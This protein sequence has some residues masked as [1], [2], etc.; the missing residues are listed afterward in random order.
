MEKRLRWCA[1]KF[2]YARGSSRLLHFMELKD[3]AIDDALDYS[4]LFFLRALRTR[5]G[6]E[7][8]RDE[9]LARWMDDTA[10]KLVGD[11]A[12][13]LLQSL[14]LD[15]QTPTTVGE[16]YPGIGATFEY[17]KLLLEDRSGEAPPSF[18]YLAFGPEALRLK[19]EVL[20]ADELFAARYYSD[21]GP[22][23]ARLKA[24]ERRP[25]LTIFNHNQ[26][27]RHRAEPGVSLDEFIPRAAG[28]TLLAA[29]ATNADVDELQTTVK[30]RAVTVPSL[31]QLGKLC[32]QTGMSWAF[33]FIPGFDKDFFLPNGDSRLGLLLAYGAGRPFL[34]PGFAPLPRS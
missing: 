28:P 16:F 8:L 20:H 22:E 26:S 12:D 23:A 10:V 3:F 27:V 1:G 15:P 21:T 32:R 25:D 29:R 33:R 34:L 2:V 5:P 30:G 24:E 11:V 17:L 19:F 7:A 6:D 18:S 4:Q 13:Q 9:Q 31:K 14:A